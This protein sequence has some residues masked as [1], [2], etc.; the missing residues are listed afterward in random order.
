MTTF[1]FLVYLT[2]WILRVY[3]Y[4]YT[5]ILYIIIYIYI[6]DIDLLNPPIRSK[7]FV[8]PVDQRLLGDAVA[9]RPR[10]AE[11]T[12]KPWIFV[13]GDNSNSELAEMMGTC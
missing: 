10:V 7:F 12:S 3:I 5:S 6:I 8:I 9:F 2:T 13:S 11:T 4:I 1:L